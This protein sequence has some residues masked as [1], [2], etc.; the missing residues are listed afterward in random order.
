[1]HESLA[2]VVIVVLVQR[3][4]HPPVVDNTVIIKKVLPRYEFLHEKMVVYL[5]KKYILIYSLVNIF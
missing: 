1:M 2:H 4:F 5:Y 3:C